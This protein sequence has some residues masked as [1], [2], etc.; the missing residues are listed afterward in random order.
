MRPGGQVAAVAERGENQV[1]RLR[2]QHAPGLV[3]TVAFD[4]EF[5]GLWQQAVMD[6]A[7]AGEHLLVR[8]GPEEAEVQFFLGPHGWQRE[9]AGRAR[10]ALDIVGVA[11]EATEP[12]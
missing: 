4:N 1:A 9:I 10:F 3:P 2:A 5:F 7:H 12:G 6:A 11:G 8:T